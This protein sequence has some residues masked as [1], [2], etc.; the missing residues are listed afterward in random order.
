MSREFEG[1]VVLVT[2]AAR[3]LG[4]EIR[5]GFASAGADVIGV[6]IAGDDVVRADVGTAEGVTSMIAD[7][8]RLH[9]KL[10][11]L[12]LNAGIQHKSPIEEFPDDRWDALHNVMLRGPF[13]AMRTAWPHLR[14]SRGNIVVIS[15]TSAVAAEPSKAAY[16]SAKAGVAGLVRAAALDGAIDGIRVNAVAPGW[17][18]T[19]MAEAQVAELARDR[20]IPESNA[21]RLLLDRQ[22]LGRF[23][24]LSEVADAVM[25][26]AS[27]RASAITGILLPVDGGLLAG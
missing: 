17:M 13:Q 23:V 25:F 11:V 6:D 21:M 20:G 14:A 24:E 19:P 1:K 9:G 22:P 7:T 18:R 12:V 16:V 4:A 5:R 10:D 15:S 2:G 3:G 27:D 8:L 26:L